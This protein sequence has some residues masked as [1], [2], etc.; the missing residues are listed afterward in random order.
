MEVTGKL[1]SLDLL[2]KNHLLSIAKQCNLKTFGKSKEN[3][4]TLIDGHFSINF[5]NHPRN[6]DNFLLFRAENEFRTDTYL[7]LNDLSKGNLIQIFEWY[8]LVKPSISLRCTSKT[9]LR[10]FIDKALQFFLLLHLKH[11][12]MSFLALPTDLEQLEQIM[13]EKLT[14]MLNNNGKKKAIKEV[15][16]KGNSIE[17]IQYAS[18]RNS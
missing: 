3:L 8:R 7:T 18:L 11:Y 17:E 16:L 1:V 4:L 6:F 13:K 5:P 15:Q 2:S 9:D 14:G 10:D 12:W